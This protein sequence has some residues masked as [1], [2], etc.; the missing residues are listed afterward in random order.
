MR[1]DEV[2]NRLAKAPEVVFSNRC[3]AMKRETGGT[4]LDF[5][6][7]MARSRCEVQTEA[8]GFRLVKRDRGFE[9]SLGVIV[10]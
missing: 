5:A 8:S 4:L 6:N 2:E 9:F 10:E 7:G 1:K 3:D